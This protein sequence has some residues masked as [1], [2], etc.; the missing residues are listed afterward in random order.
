MRLTPR[1]LAV[2]VP[3][4][5]VLAACGDDSDEGT[6]ATEAPADDA[7][8]APEGLVSE[9]TLTVCSDT[10]YEPFEFKD[11]AGTDTGYD[12][13][14]LRAIADT[15][16]LEMAV[17]DLPFDGILGSLAAGDCDVVGSAVSITDE[18]KEQVD[19]S[20]PYFDS[21]QSLLIKAEDGGE[22]TS[23]E[24]FDG[25]PL[26]VQ[27]GTTGE[28]F[29]NENATGATVTSFEDSDGLFAALEAGEI[30]GI[31]QDL[32][33]NGYRTTQ[34][35]SLVMIEEFPTDEQYGFAVAK[36]NT[37]VLDFLN[38]GLTTLRDDGGFDEIYATYF[39]EAE[40]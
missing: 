8:A 33:V 39:G 22:I 31:L 9:G 1:F 4:A 19:F 32:P 21:A 25:R 29:A 30:D 5:L 6:D 27:S 2:L 12:M 26:G 24:D 40:A 7:V 10:P 20:D 15:A 28:T 16:D 36:D 38:T 3:V 11:D 35:D 13:D 37:A 18:R 14:L 34:D 23:L 17:I